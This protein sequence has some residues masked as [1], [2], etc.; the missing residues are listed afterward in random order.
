MPVQMIGIDYEKA[1]LDIRSVFALQGQKGEQA[2]LTIKNQEPVNGVVLIATCN[3]TELYISTRNPVERLSDI[4][5]SLCEAD[6]ERYSEYFV[7][8]Q[9][10]EAIDHLFLLACGM[11]SKVFGEDQI[12]S[13]VKNALSQ[14]RELHTTDPLLEKM[15]Q[16]AITAAKKVKSSVR[17]TAVE[18]SVVREMGQTLLREFADLK[19]KK[20]LVIGNGEIGRLAAKQLVELGAR[21]TVTVRNYKTR[22]VEIPTG[23]RMID[24]RERYEVLRDFDI[25]VSAT[26]SPHH[27]IKYEDC[28]TLLEDGRH[29]VLVDLAV[30]RDISSRFAQVQNIHLYNIDS[31]GGANTDVN[32][33]QV[34]EALKI[35]EEYKKRLQIDGDI[36]GYIHTIQKIGQEGGELSYG[37]IEKE[38]RSLVMEEHR[39]LVRQ[40]VVCGAEKTITSMLFDLRKKVSSEAWMECIDALGNK[41]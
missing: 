37:R 36:K 12:I 29:R 27:T 4:V 17:L 21:V 35:I 24:Y 10:E 6:T 8:R 38:L 5:C 18:A 28:H 39:E 2:L 20:C 13:Q 31:L 34:K 1:N 3:R 23:C 25:I 11:K 19:E 7:E 40:L 41:E 16:Y 30:P 22:Q 14:A 15:F 26:T 9:E 33:Q 32:N